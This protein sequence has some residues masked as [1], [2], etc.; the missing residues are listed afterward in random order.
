MDLVLGGRDYQAP[1]GATPPSSGCE[2]AISMCCLQH[3]IKGLFQKQTK[4]CTSAHT[5]HHCTAT[6]TQ[7]GGL[8]ASASESPKAWGVWGRRQTE[9]F[10]LFSQES[11]TLGRARM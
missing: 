11:V 6:H 4:K 9:R 2:L 7:P 3:S 1:A 10:G 5:N 8:A